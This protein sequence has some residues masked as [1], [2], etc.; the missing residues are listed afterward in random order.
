MRVAAVAPVPRDDYRPPLLTGT[1]A[2]PGMFIAGM[3]LHGYS[4]GQDGTAGPIRIR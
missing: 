4:L 3:P 2:F 1:D